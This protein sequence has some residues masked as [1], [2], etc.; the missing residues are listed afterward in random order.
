VNNIIAFL[1]GIVVGNSNK[2]QNKVWKE[3][4]IECIEMWANDIGCHWVHYCLTNFYH[5]FKQ[6]LRY[7]VHKNE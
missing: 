3:N 1:V 4:S 2:L 6:I 7:H 5:N